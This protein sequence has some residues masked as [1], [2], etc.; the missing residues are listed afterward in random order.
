MQSFEIC[1]CQDLARSCHR[2][3]KTQTL[4]CTSTFECV[5]LCMCACTIKFGPLC[6]H[7]CPIIRLCSWCLKPA[8][9]NTSI[10]NYS[11]RMDSHTVHVH[12]SMPSPQMTN[13]STK[14]CLR[15]LAYCPG[16]MSD[17]WQLTG[18]FRTT[19]LCLIIHQERKRWQKPLLLCCKLTNAQ[20]RKGTCKD[21]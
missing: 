17:V 10:F 4:L 15:W 7:C 5:Y 8:C 3:T 20:A 2:I 1:W 14:D 18:D 6:F 19:V 11:T 9:M 16:R 21:A 12:R 13:S